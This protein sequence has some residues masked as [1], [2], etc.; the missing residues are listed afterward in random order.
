MIDG[1]RGNIKPQAFLYSLQ[2]LRMPILL[3]CYFI[4]LLW[5]LRGSDFL[6]LGCSVKNMWMEKEC[7]RFLYGRDMTIVIIVLIAVSRRR[8]NCEWRI[9]LGSL[10]AAYVGKKERKCNNNNDKLIDISDGKFILFCNAKYRLT[11]V[12]SPLLKT[13]NSE[14][15]IVQ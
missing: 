2:Q 15:R 1:G 14:K 5:G 13:S 8:K 3:F 10:I 12:A 9:E 6:F 7:V 11:V 4:I